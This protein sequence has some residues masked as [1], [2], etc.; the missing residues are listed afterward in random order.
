MIRMP[1][2]Q[3]RPGP[4]LRRSS[5]APSAAGSRPGVGVSSLSVAGLLLLTAAAPAAANGGPVNYVAH[6]GYG[7]IVPIDETQVRLVSEDLTLSV[8]FDSENGSYYR[9]RADYVLR[10]DGP[11]KDVVFGVPMEWDSDVASAS[12]RSGKPFPPELAAQEARRVRL[13]FDGKRA[14]CTPRAERPA[15][16]AR[17][18]LDAPEI[19]QGWCIV[20]LG[21]PRRARIPLRLEITSFL[22]RFED[23]SSQLGYWL[24]PAGGWAGPVERLRIRADVGP[25][26]PLA[27]VVSP[28]GARLSGRRIE[29]DLR[30]VSLKALDS[31]K[32]Q[33]PTGFGFPE[34]YGWIRAAA[35]VTVTSGGRRLDVLSDGDRATRWCGD[36]PATF[37]ATA[38]PID[39]APGQRCSAR[40]LAFSTDWIDAPYWSDRGTSITAMRISACRSPN[41]GIDL[42]LA[43]HGRAYLR[44]TADHGSLGEAVFPEGR[45][46]GAPACLSVDVTKLDPRAN[47]KF[48]LGELLPRVY[49]RD[50]KVKR[51]TLEQVRYELR[52]K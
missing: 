20:T 46:E 33:L 15:G 51:P 18:S 50:E 52:G 36:A 2:T 24:A 30:D 25:F 14:K 45:L 40:D 47:G 8:V 7:G 17:H 11:P 4:R 28:A 16:A 1:R 41:D 39:L 27:K 3:A 44:D 6:A 37:E 29:W 5:R 22:R 9:A 35:Q 49:C 19:T 42:D 32:I 13:M 23:G 26:A 10:N 21:V 31:V 48:C 43:R 38:V 12:A 34:G